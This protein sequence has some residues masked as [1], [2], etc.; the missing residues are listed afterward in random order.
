MHY[1]AEFNAMQEEV[2]LVDIFEYLCKN[3]LS[4]NHQNSRGDTP[5]H[6]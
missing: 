4:V 6:R 2:H 5:L 1:L 3:G